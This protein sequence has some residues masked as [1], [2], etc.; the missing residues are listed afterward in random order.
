MESAEEYKDVDCGAEDERGDNDKDAN[1]NRL[2]VEP[3]AR[4]LV[5]RRGEEADGGTCKAAERT[6]R[7]CECRAQRGARVG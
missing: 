5:G 6:N 3:S 7:P 1:T 4:G 2:A